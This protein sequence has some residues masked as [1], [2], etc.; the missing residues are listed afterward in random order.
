MQ[1]TPVET[2]FEP[3]ANDPRILA[4]IDAQ[5]RLEVAMMGLDLPSVETLMAPDLVVHA[6]INLVVNRE[7]V[8]ARLRGGQISYDDVVR[9][10]SFA[11]VRGETVVLMGEEVVTPNRDAPNA[12]RLVHRRFTDIWTDASGAWRLIVRQATNTSVE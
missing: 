2:V 11:G 4:A 9:T 3:S 5:K 8:L 6:P 1:S 12:G 10:I 7:N